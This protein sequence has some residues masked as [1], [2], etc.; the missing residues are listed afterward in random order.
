[1]D[2]L[3]GFLANKCVGTYDLKRVCALIFLMIATISL[4]GCFNFKKWGMF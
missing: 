4:G 2:K 1:M 3:V